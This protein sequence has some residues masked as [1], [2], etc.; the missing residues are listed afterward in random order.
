MRGLCGRRILANLEVEE[1]LRRGARKPG[2]GARRDGVP[3]SGEPGNALSAA[4]R[5]TAA[6]AGTLLRAFAAGDDR[7]WLPAPV[8]AERLGRI[9]GLPE[10][11]LEDGALETLEPVRRVL[12]WGESPRTAEVRERWGAV[13]DG[14]LDPLRAPV[15]QAVWHV[16]P[17]P[18][19]AVA[20][21]AHRRFCLELARELDLGLP[22][23]R[24]VRDPAEIEDHLR[25]SGAAS[26]RGRWV[27][28]APYSAAGRERLVGSGPEVLRD[29]RD[30]RRLEELFRRH[31]SLLFEPWV[32]RFADFGC[33][34][35]VTPQGVRFAG[36]HRLEVDE[37]GVFRGVVVARHG[38]GVPG[39]TSD[40][41][42]ALEG[43]FHE[44]AGSLA[45]AG[46]TGPVGLDAYRWRAPDGRVRFHPMGEINPRLTFGL[47]ARALAERVKGDAARLVLGRRA[48]AGA[49]TL[50]HPSSDGSPG[51]WL[52]PGDAG[53]G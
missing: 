43:T 28:K 13:S 53:A 12:A 31:G 4:A 51:A 22:G 29:P 47:V 26:G 20:R 8:A 32:E 44:V 23:A 6:S 52:V 35:L 7:L 14:G 19:A 3:G 30:R 10:P 17:A 16:A 34:G 49:L 42:E 45:A 5:R 24:M 18:P 2:S 33:A 37:R 50:L 9:G 38:S 46:Y 39:L 40:E 41:G 25:R 21:V 11:E 15:H 27:V 1:D 36:S 48:P